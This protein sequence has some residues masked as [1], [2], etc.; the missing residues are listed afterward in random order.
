VPLW[1]AA[2][3]WEAANLVPIDRA[4]EEGLSFRPLADTITAALG[5]ETPPKLVTALPRKRERELLGRLAQA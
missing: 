2:P 4:L 5:D 3:G 1:I